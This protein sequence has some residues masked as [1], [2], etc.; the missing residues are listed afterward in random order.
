MVIQFE[1][2]NFKQLND[3]VNHL[4]EDFDIILLDSNLPDSHGIINISKQ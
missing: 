3:G 1:L 4:K 2:I